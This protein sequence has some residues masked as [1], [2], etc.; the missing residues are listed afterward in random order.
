MARVVD[1]GGAAK[2]HASGG[3]GG[4]W[5]PGWYRARL[6]SVEHHRTAA[7]GWGW[8]TE[9][10][11]GDIGKTVRSFVNGQ[12]IPRDRSERAVK[13]AEKA[14]EIGDNEQRAIA[15]ACGWTNP[16]DLDSDMRQLKGKALMVYVDVEGGRDGYGPSMRPMRYTRLKDPD[17]Q[18][19]MEAG[20][21]PAWAQAELQEH[22][23]RRQS[24]TARGAG[25]TDPMATGTQWPSQVSEPGDPGATRAPDDIDDDIPF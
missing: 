1:V 21:A 17:V 24:D 22:L 8:K 25:G 18:H 15:D 20:E 11:L 14:Q 16:F 3:S 6:Q 10:N 2:A 4:L 12:V 23:A 5:A 19:S 7:G 13:G 9:L